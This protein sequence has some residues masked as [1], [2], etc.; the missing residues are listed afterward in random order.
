VDH[1]EIEKV[2]QYNIPLEAYAVDQ[3]LR[4]QVMS[5]KLYMGRVEWALLISLSAIWGG[6][7]FFAKVALVDLP[8]FTLVFLRVSIAAS[9]LWLVMR[10]LGAELPKSGR[11]WAAFFAMGFLNNLVP[12]SLLFWGQTQ[13]GAGLASVFNALV[14]VFT[15]IVAHIWTTDEKLSYGKFMGA[16]LG[17][18][19]VTVMI[20]VDIGNGMGWWTIL[21]MLGCIAAAGSY[22]LATVYGRRFKAMDVAPM[23]V[24]FGQ[25]TA[26]AIMML[27]VM[28][29]VDQPWTL[30][31]VSSSTIGAVMGLALVSTALGYVIF[32]RILERGG[33]TNISLVAF[34]IPVSAILLGTQF[35]DES[36]ALHHIAGMG[37]I[38]A[39]L[40][41][42]DGRL[43]TKMRGFRE[44][45]ARSKICQA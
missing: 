10:L 29:V 14:P 15:V 3:L 22:G 35:L 9:A 8:P 4:R 11:L 25:L 18:I 24:A 33:A 16:L 2:D 23:S 17:I 32:F 6:S 20:G 5:T 19:G 31:V 41:A 21:A 39:G 13:I 40:I 7:F 37:L 43:A 26:S 36:L 34:L 45:T 12:F 44:S 27:P 42:L 38:F 28:V 1:R 30:V